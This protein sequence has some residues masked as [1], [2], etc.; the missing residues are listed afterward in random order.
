M[1]DAMCRK[2]KAV[3]LE[4]RIIQYML[5]IV[6]HLYHLNFPRINLTFK[7]N[8]IFILSSRHFQ[9]QRVQTGCLLSEENDP[10]FMVS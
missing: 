4:V 9:A 3:K 8:K 2:I 1:C 5:K 7:K 6:E 10:G